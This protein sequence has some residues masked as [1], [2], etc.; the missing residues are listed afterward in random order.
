MQCQPHILCAK[1]NLEIQSDF[2]GPVYE[3]KG[4]KVYFIAS[5]DRFSK[6]PTACIFDKASSPNVTNFLD[7]YI[8]NDVVP[9]KIQ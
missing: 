9:R 1:P 6:C 3:E 4:N 5:I 8:Q 2:G 7:I